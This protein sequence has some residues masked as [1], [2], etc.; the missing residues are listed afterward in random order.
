M[1]YGKSAKI[2]LKQGVGTRGVIAELMKP[3]SFFYP[4]SGVC[5]GT[6]HQDITL[7]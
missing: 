6:T 7:G 5:G 4:G 3:P 1:N 2:A